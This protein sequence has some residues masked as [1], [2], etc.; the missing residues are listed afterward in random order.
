MG[1][2]SGNIWNCL[3]A[4]ENKDM[5]LDLYARSNSIPD[6]LASKLFL[7]WFQVIAERW[8]ESLFLF[9]ALEKILLHLFKIGLNFH[10]CLQTFSR[11]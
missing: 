9:F 1:T 4:K 8:Q 11:T 7:V 10:K 6:F 5:A 2:R 3:E